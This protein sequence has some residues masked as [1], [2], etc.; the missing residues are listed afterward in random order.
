MKIH[1]RDGRSIYGAAV[2]IK[3]GG[4]T[5]KG[6]SLA[7]GSYQINPSELFSPGE[8][9]NDMIELMVSGGKSAPGFSETITVARD[10]ERN[11][12]LTADL[13]RRI[14]APVPLDIVFVMDTTGSM[15]EEIYRL[16]NTIQIIHMNLSALAVAAD[17][18][19]GMVL[20]KDDGDDY[21]TMQIPLTTD[22]EEFQAS[23][24]QVEAYGGGDH[25]E[26]LEAALDDLVNEM[27]W[28]PDA[29]KIAYVITDAPPHLDYQRS[30]DSADALRDA[31]QKGIKIFTIGT[32]GLDLQGEYNLRQIAQYTSARYIFL[33]YGTE[34]GESSGG[35]PGSVS[36][37]TGSN[38][39]ADKLETIIIRFTREEL[40]HLSDS[41][42]LDEDP[43]FEAGIIEAEDAE[44]TLAN[45]F[46][47]A[48][49]QLMDFSTLP[50]GDKTLVA[51]MPFS[52]EGDIAADAEY[53]NE[54]LILAAGN[55]ERIKLAE[56]KDIAQL[57]NEL[58]F[59]NLGLTDED[60]VGRIGEFLNADILIGG[61]LFIKDGNYELF[62]RM[63]R[64]E[65]AEVLSVTRAV[66]DAGLGL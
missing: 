25:P 20:Y 12:E 17:I 53:F 18:R 40:S 47:Q 48:L 66:I 34:S 11:I 52:Y 24:D 35:A 59:Q 4:K 27:D 10:A 9:S 57:L 3:A 13:S 2:E 32:G 33:T 50:V 7:D 28:K 58:E 56:R 42:L 54:H 65:T 23:L 1:D 43:W 46:D 16:K 31:R 61:N 39:N 22:L 19:F 26:D 14:P 38:W 30:Y 21:T 6:V 55:N 44:E 49:E 29:V 5:V 15:G 62:L 37:H 64:V 51:V 63:M 60:S 41:P 45:L 36:H 8:R